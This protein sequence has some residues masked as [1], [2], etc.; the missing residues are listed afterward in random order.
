MSIEKLIRDANPVRTGDLAAG[1]SPHARRALAQILQPH[2]APSVTASQAQ[3]RG[4]PVRRVK[5]RTP[6]TAGLAFTAAGA[7]VA[8]LVSA[9]PGAPPRAAIGA[10]TAPGARRPARAH[11]RTAQP[12]T[13]RQVLLTAAAHVAS[14]PV[15]GKYWRVTMI[16]GVTVPA[17]TKASPYDI[18]LRTY[19]DQWNPSSAGQKEW[20]IF[21][22]P[23]TRPAT[24]ADAAAW[25]AAG[26]PT[27]WHSGLPPNSYL[28]GL[29]NEWVNPLAATTAASARSAGWN[30]SDGTVGFVEGDLAGLKAAQFRRIRPRHVEA[31][32]RHYAKL[33]HCRSSI[34]STVN[35]LVWAEALALLQDPVSAPV[36]S[37]TFKVMAGLPGVRLIGEMTDPLGRPGYALAPGS[38]DPNADPS[39]FNPTRVVL[40]DP[41]S[42]SL[43]ATAEIGPMP[44][45]VHCLSFNAKNNCTGPAYYGRSYPDQVDDYAAV[46]SEGWTNASP[47][48]PPP[49]RWSAQTGGYPGLPPLP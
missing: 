47:V 14:G 19:A 15:T 38:Q 43:L 40:I 42:G 36:R 48:L 44:R 45:N 28:D 12:L 9:A 34:C 22:H 32:L 24:P 10:A 21:R 4:R 5:K 3:H 1:D 39:H 35:Q 31:L 17:G 23:G 2:A 6:M 20:Q 26:S 18:S 27:T 37:A 16:G 49:S 25:R 13:A 46:V 30:V 11:P 8:V 29:P 41:R 7:V 33:A